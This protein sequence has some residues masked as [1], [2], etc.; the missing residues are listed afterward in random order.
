[1][2]PLTAKFFEWKV[3]G[4]GGRCAPVGLRA[5]RYLHS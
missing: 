2:Q 4:S 1:M 3:H 5:R